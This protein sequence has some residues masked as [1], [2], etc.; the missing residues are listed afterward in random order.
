[1]WALQLAGYR[2]C[3]KTSPRSHF[4]GELQWA[5]YASQVTEGLSIDKTGKES[6][7]RVGIPRF[8]PSPPSRLQHN[9][10]DTGRVVCG[11]VLL[12]ATKAALATG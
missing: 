4:S 7:M 3:A 11:M 6:S 12:K 2:V 10:E 5:D 8:I 1:M 9:Y